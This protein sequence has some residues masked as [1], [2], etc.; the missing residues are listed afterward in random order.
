MDIWTLI[1][2]GLQ[3]LL[4]NKKHKKQ[5]E[6]PTNEDTW[7]ED[8]TE[9]KV[10]KLIDGPYSIHDLEEDYEGDEF[11][12]IDAMVEIDGDLMDMTICHEDFDEIYTIVKHL[13]SATVEPYIL[14]KQDD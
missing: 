10:H 8:K 6:K 9:I 5:S 4:S 7:T 11:F 14:G 3:S 1:K 13:G 12:F 2:S